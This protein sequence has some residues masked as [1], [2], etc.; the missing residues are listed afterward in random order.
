MFV[1]LEACQ[2]ANDTGH[3]HRALTPWRAEVEI[4]IVIFHEPIATD[5]VLYRY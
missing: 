3:C 2:M 1:E 5:A 4:E